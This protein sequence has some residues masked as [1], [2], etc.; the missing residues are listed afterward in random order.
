MNGKKFRDNRTGEVVKVIDA[1]ENIAILENKQKIDVRRLNDP[2]YFTEEIDPASFFNNQ[3]AYNNLAEKIKNIPTNNII[4]EDGPVNTSNGQSVDYSDTSYNPPV[5]NDSAIIMSTVDDEREELARK[6]GVNLN[7]TQAVVKQNEAFAQILGDENVNE[8]PVP[9]VTQNTVYNDVQK[10]EV[11]RDEEGE[12]V[13]RPVARQEDPIH[14]MFRNAKKVVEFNLD[15]QLINKIPRLDFIEMMED[16]YEKSIIDFLAT[17]IT[18]D[19]LKNPDNLK[20]QVS[21]KIKEMVYNRKPVRKAPA[22]KPVAK[23]PVTKPTKLKEDLKTITEAET[24]K[25]VRK[26]R[27]KKETEQHD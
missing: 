15:L 19:L 21:E 14:V 9:V 5:D 11:R 20:F 12:V 26:P 24:K 3:G 2:N 25:P 6:Y 16:S 7:N 23:K 4:D 17:E 1:F 10:V 27:V 22:K 18:N 13:Q 8:L